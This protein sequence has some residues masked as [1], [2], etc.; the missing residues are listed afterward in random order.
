MMQIA[1]ILFVFIPIVTAIFIYLFKNPKFSRIVF[2]V[3]PLIIGLFVLYALY[4]GDHPDQ[5]LLILGGSETMIRISFYNDSLSL[6]F[7]GLTSFMWMVILLYTFNTNRKESTFLFFLMFLQGVFMGMVQTNDLFN[8]FVFIELITVLVTILI[9]YKKT[10]PSFRA[11]IYY[12]LLNALAAMIFLIGIIFMY[13]VYGTI[14]IQYILA[15]IGEHSDSQTIRLAY[16]FM[17]AGISVKA[18][19]FPVYAWLPKAHA[20]AQSTI[21]A[22]LS[23]LIV[24]GA[25]YMFLR[26]N[27]QMFAAAQYDTK[28]LFFWI[29]A[30]TALA[31]VV[32]AISQK[33]L[34]Q[35]LAH[36]TI[37]QV[38]IMMMGISSVYSLASFGG[39]L[40]IFNHAFFKSLLFLGAGVVIKVYQTKYV[41]DIRGVFR[42]MPWT[43]ILLIVGMLSISG[44]PI[45][46]GY[47]S[48]T[49]I[50]TDFKDDLLKMWV[51]NLIN[52][53]TITSF[54]KFSTILFGPK[55]PFQ[56]D[57]N[58]KQH[59]GMSFL[60]IACLA[61]GLFYQPL[62]A[63]LF[64]I[65]LS[66]VTWLKFESFIEYLL[67][68]GIGLM[69]Y[70]F[71]INKD[72]W[73]TRK[74]RSI[75]ITFEA[76][77]YLFVVYLLVIAVFIFTWV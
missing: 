5:N 9:S 36:H 77:N 19:L 27:D 70:H 11:S 3:Q 20:V 72:Y 10:G 23:G 1:P 60:A 47:V 50:K 31:G 49:L 61:V 37:S 30:I 48:K 7:V 42:T 40:H 76:A 22:L 25:L 57:P 29:G 41:K 13:Y 44:A 17:I 73:P 46:N 74:L 52:L 43:A 28:E 53:G 68:I 35:I 71:V 32:L 16:I 15:H 62:G 8:L 59:V 66:Y 51:F 24:K 26:I 6:A 45:F 34:K 33:D 75:N 55:K 63:W 4:L 58:I 12:L 64:S 2:V 65:D 54:I 56:I 21:S 14:N 39:F 38:G 18:A 69:L 67:Y